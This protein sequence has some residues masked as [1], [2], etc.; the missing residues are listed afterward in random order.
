MNV[1]NLIAQRENCEKKDMDQW[2]QSDNDID[3]VWEKL[4]FTEKQNWYINDDS[5][6]VS[7]EL[8]IHGKL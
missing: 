6:K 8:V 1:N 7:R 2:W 3:E 4:S 5:A